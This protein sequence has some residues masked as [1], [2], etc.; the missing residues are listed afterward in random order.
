M[1]LLSQLWGYLLLACLLGALIGLTARRVVRAVQL[2]HTLEAV[3]FRHTEQM[4][5]VSAEHEAALAALAEMRNELERTRQ[6][7]GSTHDMQQRI[8][9]R[10]QQL[11]ELGSQLTRVSQELSRTRSQQQ[12]VTL[13]R[14]KAASEIEALRS[15]VVS[16]RT[17]LAQAVNNHEQE[18]AALVRQLVALM[19]AAAQQAAPA[20]APAGPGTFSA[21]AAMAALPVQAGRAPVAPAPAAMAPGAA[22]P[23]SPVPAAA[24]PSTAPKVADE[25]MQAAIQAGVA[26]AMAHAGPATNRGQA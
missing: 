8:E 2:Q 13:E 12:Q 20:E 5:G 22:A 18:K 19:P 23:M 1:F 17:R 21:A 24:M 7:G 9:L 16:S 4:A 15:Q 14:Q 26:A 11:K 10:E 6:E 25:D 3:E